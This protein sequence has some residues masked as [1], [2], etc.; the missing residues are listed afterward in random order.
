MKIKGRSFRYALFAVLVLIFGTGTSACWAQEPALRTTAS[1][2]GMSLQAFERTSAVL[3]P[4]AVT[5]MPRQERSEKAENSF[6]NGLLSYRA[7]E[8]TLRS[9]LGQIGKLAHV[10]MRF[11]EGLGSE[12][13]SVEFRH[14]RVDEA[15][16]QILKEYDAVFFYGADKENQGSAVLKA[17]SV[18]PAGQGPEISRS[19]PSAWKS[20]T[21]EV[22]GMLAHPDPEVRARAA[23]SLIRRKGPESSAAVLAALKDKNES[24]RAQ[25]LYRAL[26]SGVEIPSDALVDL[27]LNDESMNVRFLALQALPVDPTLRWVA[28]RAAND[29][30]QQVSA[31]AK[32]IL[33]ELDA[34]NAPTN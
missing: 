34:A 11:A 13:I 29:S 33:K 9:I 16:R 8:Q 12:Q 24:V 4:S 25:A 19:L 23:M 27:A 1:G 10:E 22:E 32:D 30:S 7:K 5:A 3:S 18:H 26:M 17:V 28:E 21:G 31:M 6:E 20:R 2:A 14:F 15:L